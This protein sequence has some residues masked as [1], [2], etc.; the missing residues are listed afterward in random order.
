MWF[1]S[2]RPGIFG[3][4]RLWIHPPAVKKGSFEGQ[5]GAA[6]IKPTYGLNWKNERMSSLPTRAFLG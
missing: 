6:R 3:R 2:Y 1:D 5:G 4:L